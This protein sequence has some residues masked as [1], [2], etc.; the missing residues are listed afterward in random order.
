[1]GRNTIGQFQKLFQPVTFADAEPFDIDPAFA[2]GQ[3][4]A[5]GDD[6]DVDQV[7]ALVAFESGI[8]HALQAVPRFAIQRQAHDSPPCGKGS[9]PSGKDYS[10]TPLS[11]TTEQHL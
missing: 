10:P 7:M 2:S 5:Q 6:Q 9:Y 11:E 1:M 4:T 8:D 3:E